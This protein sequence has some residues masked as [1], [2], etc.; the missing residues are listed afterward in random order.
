[1]AKTA[2]V[3][4]MKYSFSMASLQVSPPS[5]RQKLDSIQNQSATILMAE[6]NKIIKDKE[7][8]RQLHINI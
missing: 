1:M 5:I 2:V 7:E 8:E 6:K 4:N 3:D